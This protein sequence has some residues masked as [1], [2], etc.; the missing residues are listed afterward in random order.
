MF[1]IDGYRQNPGPLSVP[2]SL[3]VGLSL[4]RI[5]FQRTGKDGQ[6]VRWVGVEL[7]VFSYVTSSTSGGL[8]YQPLQFCAKQYVHPVPDLRFINYVSCLRMY[9]HLQ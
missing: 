1:V 4:P 7:V 8:T 6:A 2:F 3:S 9:V 5:L